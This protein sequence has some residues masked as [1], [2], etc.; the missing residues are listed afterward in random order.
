[1]LDTNRLRVFRSVMASGS[2][3]AAAANLGYTASAISQQISALQRETGLS[4]FEK[5]GRG[6]AP[7]PAAEALYARS[8]ELMSEL[9]K[10]GTVVDDLREGRSSSLTVGYFASAGATWIPQMGRALMAELPDLR[11]NFLLTESRG[12]RVPVDIELIIEH[13]ESTAP[14][15]GFSR[16][17][18]LDDDYVLAVPCSHEFASRGVLP[19]S[20]LAGQ[21]LVQFDAMANPC[22]I[23]AQ[24]AC[25]AA[26][27]SPVYSV[28]SEDHYTA[29]AFVA[30]G[31]GM[32]LIP[33]LATTNLP[34]GVVLV[35][36]TDP[37]PVRWI[38]L[39]IRESAVPNL[40][41]ERAVEILQQIVASSDALEVP[42]AV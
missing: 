6:I 5:A 3:Q 7:T 20:E 41:A 18:L 15:D 29:L 38:S 1:M 36:V 39:L 27:F 35:E 23:V 9:T 16:V 4:L 17:P 8:E 24:R 14:P 37:T 34:P 10:L 33:R 40:A 32:G 13:A 26:G 21:K 22:Q 30:A 19:L 11:L 42:S 12:A 25:E 28:H 2:I 31:M